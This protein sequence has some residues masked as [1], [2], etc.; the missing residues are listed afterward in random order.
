MGKPDT[1]FIFN[2][3]SLSGSAEQH[4]DPVARHAEEVGI[5]LER[6]ETR[7][8]PG[9]RDLARD[10][11]MSGQFRTIVALGGDGTI[12]EVVQGMMLARDTADIPRDDLPS[13]A[14][15]PFGTGNNIAKSFGIEPILGPMGIIKD[16]LER[17][18]EAVKYGADFRF[19]LGKVDGRYFADAFSIGL[20]PSILRE[21]NLE[22]KRVQKI[23]FLRQ[24][25]R[26]YMLYTYVFARV[27]FTHKHVSAT[28]EMDDDREFD[29]DH[30]TNLVVNNTKVYAGEFIFSGDSRANDGLLD[31]VLF[32]GWRDYLSKFIA[33]SR[34]TPINPKMLRKALV[35]HSSY[36]KTRTVRV[37]LERPLASQID[38]E[39]YRTG[40]LFE[41]SAVENALTF[42]T[43]V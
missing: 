27:P 33:A 30:L 35:R 1:A 23:P 14:V 9:T 8:S 6:I 39:E 38:G 34:A 22:H 19:D 25:L 37:R 4:W 26:D 40:D 15:I 21:R 11:T 3:S 16:N 31:V 42:K 13:L 32:T 20:D 29:M 36:Y 5:E 41:V 43:P 24:I 10:L 17:A 28:I 18:V 7:P 12:S 2:P